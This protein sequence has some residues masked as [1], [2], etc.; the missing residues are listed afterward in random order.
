MPEQAGVVR[1]LLVEDEREVR[2][3]ACRILRRAG[4]AVIEA[5]NG[6]DALRVW[7]ADRAAGRAIDVVLTDLRMPTLGGRELVTMLRRD[8]PGLPVVF[9]SGDAEPPAR[10]ERE[11][12]GA[13]RYVTKPFVASE[14][15]RALREVLTPPQAPPDDV[16]DS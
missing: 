9:I 6:A 5:T 4:H 13:T 3:V 16:R 14:L 2:V 10:A 8:A 11:R 12:G 15:H 1:V 7:R